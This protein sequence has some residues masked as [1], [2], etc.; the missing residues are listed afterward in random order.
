MSTAGFI[1]G[2]GSWG[3]A[4][5]C[6]LARAGK[7]VYLFARDAAVANE[8]KHRSR[9]EKYLPNIDLPK[10][11][12]PTASLQGIDQARFVIMA[13]PS[14]TLRSSL[15]QIAPLLP[16][17]AII[18]VTAKGVELESNLLM[19]QVAAQVL[20][21][22]QVALLSGPSFATEV[23]RGLPSAITVASSDENAGKQMVDFIG[24]RVFRPYYSKDMTGV[25]VGGAVKNV[26]A[27]AAGIV[28]GLNLGENARAAIVT[29][30]LHEVMNLALKLSANPQTLMGLSGVGDLMLTCFSEQSLNFRFGNDLAR[31]K[32]KNYESVTVEGA[33]NARSICQLASSYNIEMPICENIYK[34]IYEK[35]PLSQSI[36][37]L[38][39]R[40]FKPEA[41]SN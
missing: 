41:A 5:A 8:I 14:Q 28:H 38:L 13:C 25:A 36:E 29:R 1:Y 27:I 23:A 30:G 33:I 17:D 19:H 18:I 34:I 40:P 11:I 22:H 15:S 2:A 9:N 16:R 20:P 39:A 31:E 35:L 12:V 21:T 4:L 3:T 32:N 10:E 37:N 6:V 26:I 24:S 7:P